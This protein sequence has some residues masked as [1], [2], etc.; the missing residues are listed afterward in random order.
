MIQYRE[1]MLQ[2]CFGFF[3]LLLYKYEIDLTLPR[4][5]CISS[6]C[7]ASNTRQIRP[8]FISPCNQMKSLR[9]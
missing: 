1:K 3:Q 7:L 4:T 9:I 8:C 6:C 5:F 2:M